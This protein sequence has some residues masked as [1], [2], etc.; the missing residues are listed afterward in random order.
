ASAQYA[1]VTPATKR[2][3]IAAQTA[4]PCARDPVIEPSVYVSPAEIAKIANIASTL[5]KGVGFSNGC[6]LLALKKPPPFVPNCL[7]IS[8]DATGPWAIVCS[9]TTVVCG[10][11]SVPV[12][13]T[14]CG[15]MTAALSYGLRFCTTPCETRNNAPTIEIGNST[16]TVA[17]VMSTQKL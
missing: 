2:K 1:T 12:V 5:L 16:H 10:L 14:V 9:V 3:A 15:S 13:V 17:R 6:A 11:P 4:H 8:C 7:M